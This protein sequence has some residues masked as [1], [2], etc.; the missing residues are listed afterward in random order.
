ME[1]SSVP[2]NPQHNTYKSLEGDN[3]KKPPVN[4]LYKQQNSELISLFRKKK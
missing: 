2:T 4:K 1:S 3:I